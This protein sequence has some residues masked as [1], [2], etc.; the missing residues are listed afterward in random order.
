MKSGDV[1]LLNFPF[2][3]LSGSKLRPAV[4]LADVGRDDFVA[5]QITSNRDADKDAVELTTTSFATGGLKVVSFARPGKLFTA[6]R[7]LFAR[8]VARFTDAVRDEI[9][10][11]TIAVIRRG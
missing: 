6:H 10:D 1:V 3:D 11:A 5:C 8:R 7:N 2:S 9:K 4:I